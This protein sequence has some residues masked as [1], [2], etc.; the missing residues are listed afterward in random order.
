MDKIYL[1]DFVKEKFKSDPVLFDAL[2]YEFDRRIYHYGDQF[3][4]PFNINSK[5]IS[6]NLRRILK[7]G[8]LISKIIS[9]SNKS[10]CKPRILSS[11]YF[12]LNSE[13]S[14]MG[15]EVFCP[16]WSLTKGKNVFP[17]LELYEG[18]H[19]IET[20]L[21]RAS[22]NYLLSDNFKVEVE[23]FK[24]QLTLSLKKHEVKAVIVANDLGFF[25]NM[26]IDVCKQIKIPSMIFLH[27]LPG[28]YNSIDDNKTDYLIVW[29]EKIKQNYIDYGFNPDKI[30]VSGHPYYKK[31]KPG[32]LA[33]SLDNILVLTK[34]MCGGQHSDKVRLTDRGNA[35]LYLLSIEKV[36][37]RFGVKSVRMRSHPSENSEWYY[38]YID[39]NFFRT[40]SRELHT[41]INDSSLVLGPT[42]TVFLESI[43]NFKNY[44]VYEPVKNGVDLF[45]YELIPP[46]DKKDTRVPIAINEIELSEIIEKRLTVKSEVFCD[47]IKIPFDLNEI[48]ELI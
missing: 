31:F 6:Q 34:P 24:K 43:Y 10:I 3:K 28:R 27:G 20:I 22:F 14:E 44:V 21:R 18:A 26:L 39:K 48:N 36:L 13:L 40:D 8:Y 38:K 41:S 15:Y 32:A 23:K 19:K 29:G 46:F 9:T 42:S 33:F 16:T 4:H 37:R 12:T 11:A 45:G 2:K 7:R 17:D 25:E 5:N 30:I 35:I 47:Y 1:L